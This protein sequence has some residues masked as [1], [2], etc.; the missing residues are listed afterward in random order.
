MNN[1]ERTALAEWVIKE[2]VKAGADEISAA[3]YNGRGINVEYRE[4]KL[5]K[6]QESSQNS[7]N[8]NVYANK[9]YSGHS[10]NDLKKESLQ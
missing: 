2:A 1:K 7:L 9:K 8:L 3:I 4:K 10:T 5:E 6:L